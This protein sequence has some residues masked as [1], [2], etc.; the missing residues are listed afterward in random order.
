[1]ALLIECD[2]GCGFADAL[3]V[4]AAEGD[5]AGIAA[6][7]VAFPVPERWSIE[8][9]AAELRRAD[10]RAWVVRQGNRIVAVALFQVVVETA[11][12]HRIVVDPDFRRAGLARQLMSAG[13]SWAANA[14]A[15][16]ML[17]EVRPDNVA[18]ITLYQSLGFKEI[19]RRR[20]YYAPG[21]DCLVMAR[22]VEEEL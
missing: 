21:V 17:L 6:L 14:R 4:V 10:R 20:D 18:A 12:L 19:S 9:W 8:T 3:A 15:T 11:D 5:A 16:R 2:P 7:E 1:M 22:D 13:I